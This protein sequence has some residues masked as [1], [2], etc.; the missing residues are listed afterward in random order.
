MRCGICWRL[1]RL[2]K[3]GDALARERI[4]TELGTTFMVEAGAGSGKTTGLVG[5]MTALI[6]TGAAEIGRIAAI[7][8]TN[9][10][11]DELK[12]RF[13]LELE[14]SLQREAPDAEK[15]R[16]T[17][18]L[19]QLDGCS[20]GTIHSFCGGMLRERPMEAGLDPAFAEMDEEEEK[21]F[22]DR[23][24]DEYL[25]QL[26]ERGETGALRDLLDDQL[27]VV[28]LKDVYERVSMFSDVQVV[29]EDCSRPDFD[30]IRL[31]LAPLVD[32][33]YAYVPANEPERGWDVLQSLLHMTK[34]RERLFGWDDDR[35]VL[36]L[37]QAFD[38]RL[39]V[40]QNRWTDGGKARDFKQAFHQWQITVL[41]PFLR[42]WREYL[43]PQLIRFVL[44]AVK[45]C[46]RRRHELGLLSFQDLLGKATVLLRD[47]PEARRYFA[48]RHR[49]VL[50]D[51][52]Q[53]TD[54][55]QAEMMFLLTGEGTDPGERDWRRLTPRP[56]SLFIVGDPKQSIYRFRRA[57]ISLYN[58]VKEKIA[59]C[60][61]VLQLNANF[62]SVHAIGDFVNYQFGSRFPAKATEEQATFVRM[63][64]QAANPRAGKRAA[65]GIFTLSHAKM[66]GGKQAVAL[67]D[68][69]K[70]AQWIAWACGEGRLQ[71]QEKGPRGEA[72][73][74]RA[75]PND[76]LILLKTTEFLHLYAEQLDMLGIPSDTSG[77]SVLYVEM[78]ALAQLAACLADPVD[79]VAL[80]GVLKGELFG[81]S[82]K[83][84]FA[85]KQEGHPFAFRSLPDRDRCSAEA[86]PVWSVLAKLY[87]YEGLVRT[88]PAMTALYRIV[89]DLAVLPGTLM[90]QAGTTRAGTLIKLLQLL[91][92]QARTAASWPELSR[93]LAELCGN[94][95]METSSVHAGGG[96]A[97]RI[98]NLHKAKGLEAPVVFLACPAGESDHDATQ[99][100]DR[101]QHPAVGYFTITRQKYD[102]VYDTV[103]QPVG[104]AELNEKERVFM[105]AEKERLLYVAATR[106]KQLLVVSLYPE[107]PAK[108]PW[109]ALMTGMEHTPELESAGSA[110]WQPEVYEGDPD[111]A[112]AA[113][114][115]ALARDRAAGPTYARLSVTR[116]TK[117]AGDVPEWSG[118][119]KGMAFGT[120]VHEGVEAMGRGR[121][122][123]TLRDYVAMLAAREGLGEDG[124][125]AAWSVLRQL[126]D[127]G[128]WRRAMAAKRRLHEAAVMIRQTPDEMFVFGPTD[129]HAA[130]EAAASGDR[131]N[132]A[133]GAAFPLAAGSTVRTVFVRGV[134]D[135]LFEEEDGWVVVDFKTDLIDERRE[136]GFV[137]FYKPQVMAYAREWER[138]FG[139]HVKEAGL[140]FTSIGKYVPVGR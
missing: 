16:L 121:A 126:A 78:H 15:A 67:A 139:F 54:P 46:E 117:E 111:L 5:R 47:Y 59:E 57:D 44:P 115:R 101:S 129:G 138:S 33:A 66:P 77:S 86:M 109:T 69:R 4:M 22:R 79:L 132:S 76:F 43:Y 90:R 37:A 87:H 82:D 75:V 85:Y 130:A 140:Y 26:E 64:T 137:R 29:T 41:F 25:L 114:V 104:W 91:Q 18:A 58:E 8:F 27:D 52:F 56:G 62:R 20:I 40:T 1:R 19:E 48:G 89:D 103:A 81:V 92:E 7:T 99:H 71:I 60:G 116:L 100:I 125:E 122:G 94:K 84:L 49:I 51:E 106:A 35:S 135:F 45:H 98:M 124:A 72:V 73:F 95:G 39:D 105:N 24:W 42:S 74:R 118:E 28:T 102:Y 113:N 127:S 61:E 3:T 96:Q 32:E 12:E 97:V 131:P 93:S 123:E 38:K 50:V 17:A 6:R 34:R 70:A 108:C 88:L 10:A 36:Q 120:V 80:L 83:E 13:R 14:R 134:I 2:T 11:A 30:L 31:S 63:E 23:C 133:S 112:D 68:A 21:R 107:Q 9:K 119:G 53:D 128:L 55:V 136:P 65:H 110:M